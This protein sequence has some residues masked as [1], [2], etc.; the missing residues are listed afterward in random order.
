[1]LKVSGDVDLVVGTWGTL[2]WIKEMN[3]KVL[4]EW[5]PYHVGGQ[6][7]GFTVKYDGM[8]LATV[9]GAGHMVPRSK[10]KEAYYL[11]ENWIKDKRF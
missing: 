10:P 5:R 3:P 7:A 2:Q 9:K 4:E 1:M 11:L 8:T 6:L